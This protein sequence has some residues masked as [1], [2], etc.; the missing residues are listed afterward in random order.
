MT[1]IA[2]AH[3]S[4]IH[5][6]DGRTSSVES[7]TVALSKAIAC[8]DLFRD[9]EAAGLLIPITGDI[10]FSGKP[11]EFSRAGA[12]ASQLV[13]EVES[14]T[15]IR[16]QVVSCPGNHDCDFQ[17]DDDVRRLVL[18]NVIDNPQSLALWMQCAT[19]QEA[20]R[21]FASEISNTCATPTS[22]VVHPHYTRTEFSI[23]GHRVDILALNTALTSQISECP[24]TLVFPV[25]LLPEALSFASADLTL[26]ILHHPLG[27]MEPNNARRLRA[28][29]EEVADLVLTGH[30][31]EASHSA[32]ICR[33]GAGNVEYIEGGVLDDGH[34]KSEFQV[35]EIDIDAKSARTR[36]F[37]WKGDA[38]TVSTDGEEFAFAR[39]ARRANN[40]VTLRKP[41][42]DWLS[43]AGASY[44]HPRVRELK[45]MDFFVHPT[46]VLNRGMTDTPLHA[47]DLLRLLETEPRILVHG[48]SESGKTA[49]A[50]WAFRGLLERGKL[51]LYIAADRIVS[52]D[53]QAFTDLELLVVAEQYVS[54]GDVVHRQADRASRVLLI[55]DFHDVPLDAG[56]RDEFLR[57]A[58]E[59]FG[60][61][62]ILSSAEIDLGDMMSSLGA[63]RAILSFA[64]CDIAPFGYRL[65]SELISRWHSLGT[66][67]NSG[68]REVVK[69]QDATERLVNSLLGKNLI[70]AYPAFV[71]I[72]LQQS[73][74]NVPLETQVGT[75]GYLYETL[76][77]AA[78]ARSTA[79]LANAKYV[80]DVRFNLLAEFAYSRFGSDRGALS[81]SE[82][83]LWLR[84]YGLRFQ[85]K[86]DP[87]ATLDDLVQCG[88]LHADLDG[89][90]DFRYRY[91]FYYF[92]ARYYAQRI[93][94]S[95]IRASIVKMCQELHHEATANVIV[96]LCH[97]TKD[98]FLVNTLVR[99][100]Q[101]LYADCSATELQFDQSALK[102]IFKPSFQWRLTARTV[103]EN[104]R[105]LHERLDSRTS[106]TGEPSEADEA[107]EA[108]IRRLNATFKS[109]QLLGQVL[110]DFA[111]SVSGLQKEKILSECVSLGLRLVGWLFEIVEQHA[112]AFTTYFQGLILAR[113][114]RLQNE[115]LELERK[116]Q[117]L[118][119]SILERFA[120]AVV[121]H[122]A[123]SV[124]SKDLELTYE[125]YFA[126]NT[127]L[128]R[129]LI[130]L[131]IKL[132]NGEGFPKREVEALA[133]DTERENFA[134]TLLQHIMWEHFRMFPVRPQLRQTLCELLGIKH[135]D[136]MMADAKRLEAKEK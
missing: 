122:V 79:T 78:L 4:D 60:A 38:Y 108:E 48:A 32:R 114:E 93:A 31:H 35:F 94:D 5:I 72:L 77:V 39:N 97:L 105:A 74:A 17:R 69:R 133:R 26:V 36:R 18:K 2:I 95:D 115:P 101:D 112:E 121:R 67:A 7:R 14:Q 20:Y 136:F 120:F 86:I 128:S 40:Q 116:T 99:A 34:G 68:D 125:P 109:I 25:D 11:S 100:A 57:R 83:L 111:G 98:E 23:S 87:Q 62:V 64:R 51:P 132:E 27:W 123:V 85:V 106:A 54:P 96:F 113:D 46:L 9:R 102:E 71:L 49:L 53:A 89:D 42:A 56:R 76:I 12:L 15:H 80:I 73:E 30:E 6:R 44:A 13:R 55:D 88:L 61:V 81:K 124:G 59:R 103:Q 129:R 45:L 28:Y 134:R 117:R 29:L 110:R 8:L 66:N 127:E 47:N 19:L 63:D 65:R 84:D 16:P 119:F 24:G 50:R 135:Q 90:V 107:T 41:F 91:A 58:V 104:R 126:A 82:V 118:F 43:D 70:P 22:V 10:S 75:L 1:K 131:L 37:L 33:T 21:A 130:Q 52:S 92:V 3:L